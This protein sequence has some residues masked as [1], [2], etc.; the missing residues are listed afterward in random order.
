[1]GRFTQEDPAKDGYNWYVYCSND[2]VNR[3]DS[4]GLKDYIYTSQ[5]EYYV[6]NDW[7]DFDFLHE[8]RYFVEIDGVRYQANSRETVELYAWASVDVD[9]L[10]STFNA[11]IDKANEKPT[12]IKRILEQS[13]GGELDFKLQMKEETLY[14]VN[15][16]LMNRNE[17]GNFVWAYFLESHYVSGYASGVLAQGGSLFPP[18]AKMKGLP[19]FDEEHDRRARW[20]GVEYFYTHNNLWWLYVILYGFGPQ[21]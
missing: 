19:R 11:L 17:A 21:I 16:V 9:F 8:D 2:S 3:Q 6:E 14:L 1:M 20:M 4:T 12:D 10:N 18:L 5:T 15:G 13:V 7:G